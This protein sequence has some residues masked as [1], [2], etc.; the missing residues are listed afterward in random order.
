MKCVLALHRLGTDKEKIMKE[1]GLAHAE[2]QAII[3][4]G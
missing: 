2:V 1:T 4:Q 3:E